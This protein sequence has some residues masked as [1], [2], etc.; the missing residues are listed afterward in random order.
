MLD[1]STAFI[2]HPAKVCTNRL[3]FY[4]ASAKS[5]C[6]LRNVCSREILDELTM[7]MDVEHSTSG[8]SS[9]KQVLLFS[10]VSFRI[11]CLKF[12]YNLVDN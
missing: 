3:E 9:V 1:S 10:K 12:N 11:F 5:R 2:H 6:T 8:A 7:G 4:L